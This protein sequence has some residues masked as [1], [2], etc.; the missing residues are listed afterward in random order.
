MTTS[1]VVVPPTTDGFASKNPTLVSCLLGCASDLS[2]GEIRFRTLANISPTFIWTAAESRH[3]FF[4]NRR[5][6]EFTVHPWKQESD[7]GWRECIH[8]EDRPAFL[9]AYQAAYSRRERFQAEFHCCHQSGTYPAQIE[10]G[11]PGR[12]GEGTLSGFI[13]TYTDASNQQEA[14]SPLIGSQRQR[15]AINFQLQ[16]SV[17]R[18]NTV[19]ST[20]HEIRTP[21][22]FEPKEFA[23]V[24]LFSG[25]TLIEISVDILDFSIIQAGRL[26]LVAQ[27]SP[28][29]SIAE[30][31]FKLVLAM[32][33]KKGL[34]RGVRLRPKIGKNW[35]GY[36]DRLHQILLNL[37]GNPIPF[38]A[39]SEVLLTLGAPGTAQEKTLVPFSIYDP[40]TTIALNQLT[41][42][43]SPN[44]DLM[45]I[46]GAEELPVAASQ[47]LDRA[48][49]PFLK[50]Q[51][52]PRL[53]AR[54]SLNQPVAR[55]VV[56]R[57]LGSVWGENG[58]SASPLPGPH[59]LSIDEAGP[60]SME[61]ASRGRQSYQSSRRSRGAQRTRRSR[62]CRGQW[63]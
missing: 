7:L 51:I 45:F 4:L 53:K 54:R 42:E 63:N 32:A 44:I 3:V 58:G 27:E 12:T 49:V 39:Q 50:R 2:S 10:Q 30:D 62:R 9:E 29:E 6:L 17:K 8:E 52:H 34:E 16:Q 20:S 28:R 11:A 21:L 33:H 48:A 61:P 15:E 46:P 37:L 1:C 24:V 56:S 26:D 60:Q 31:A 57:R 55:A 18:A 23:V 13:G 5:W 19:A 22:N 25:Q 14:G 38:T 35:W 59:A 41:F 43:A 47:H 36:P 40:G